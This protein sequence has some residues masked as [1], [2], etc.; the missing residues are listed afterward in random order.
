MTTEKTTSHVA[1]ILVNRLVSNLV[2]RFFQ[3]A[4]ETTTKILIDIQSKF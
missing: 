4:E 1:H 2:Q 3:K